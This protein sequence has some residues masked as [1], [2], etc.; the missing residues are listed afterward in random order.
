MYHTV[1]TLVV[2]L[3]AVC[4]IYALY[5]IVTKQDKY[6]APTLKESLILACAG[7]V[8][9]VADT[10]GV[11]SFAVNI[12]IAKSFK[13]VKDA[14]LP[15]FLNGAQVIPGAIE[16]VFFLGVL[17]VDALTL[18]VLI[19]GATLGGFIGGIF[20]SR[21]NTAAI[22]LI[23]IV[24]FIAMIFLLLGKLLHLLPIGGTLIALGGLK[25]AF[26]FVGL[27]MAGFLVCF[28]VGLFAIIQAVLFLLGMSP[29]V[30]FPIM[31]AA[32]AIQQPVTTVAFIFGGKVPLRK[33]LIVSLFGIVGVFIGFQIVTMLSTEQLQWLLVLVI[34][35]NVVSL[36]CSY[37]NSC[38]R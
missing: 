7:V 4:A 27:F 19:S 15:G 3:T 28:G 25:L 35:Y 10:V 29:L 2:L 21:I 32:G 26:G 5:K 23:M 11:G 14:E 16:A 24:A 36:I 13:L 18:V 12:A 31:T 17:H 37:R 6:S 8:A 33:V 20:A 38:I 22:R 34:A 1:I 30:A 9:F